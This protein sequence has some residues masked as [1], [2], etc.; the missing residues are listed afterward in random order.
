[1]LEAARRRALEA[2][3][4]EMFRPPPELDSVTVKPF[5][6]TVKSFK[7]FKLTMEIKV[8][9]IPKDKTEGGANP[10]AAD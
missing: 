2:A 8:V 4:K 7:P 6:L 3:A 9:I 5:K 1:M 10:S